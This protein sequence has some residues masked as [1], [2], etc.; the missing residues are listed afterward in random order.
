MYSVSETATILKVDGKTVKDW[1]FHFAEYLS[2]TAN[3]PKGEQRF[4]AVEDIRIFAYVLLYWEDEPDIENIKLGLNSQ[5]YYDIEP[6]NNLINQIVPIFQE[7]TEEIAGVRSNV[8]FAGMASLD[9]QLSLANS[10]KESGDI[11]F[12]TVKEQGNLYDFASPILYQYRHAIELYLKSTLSKPPR[13]HNLLKL[14]EKFE[15]LIRTKFQTAVPAWLKDMITGFNEIDPKGDIFR[16]R[17]DIASDEI[18]V[19]LLLLKTKMDWFAKGVNHICV[20][21]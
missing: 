12:E 13:T 21:S 5:D 17:E 15:A 14:Y 11:L 3:P 2:S 6:I 4:Y 9:N 18:L 20:T 16:Y 10:F 1:S 7:P 8:I 19:N